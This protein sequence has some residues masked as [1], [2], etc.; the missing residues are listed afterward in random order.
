M[1]A[2]HFRVSAAKLAGMS[3]NPKEL[4]ISMNVRVCVLVKCTSDQKL[5]GSLESKN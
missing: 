5:I 4:E 1:P 2:S 3:A